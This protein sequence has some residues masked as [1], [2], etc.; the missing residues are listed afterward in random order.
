MFNV[1]IT[2]EVTGVFDGNLTILN[3]VEGEFRCRSIRRIRLAGEGG[4]MVR[5]TG[6]FFIIFASILWSFDGLLRRNLYSLPPTVVVFYEHLIGFL[7]L[8]P[9]VLPELA[10]LKQ[11]KIK[12][13]LP[14]IWVAFFS[15]MLG[16]VLYTAALGQVNY[17]NYSVVVLLQQLEPFVA[18]TFA[19]VFLKEKVTKAYIKWALLAI[20]SAYLLSF[21]DLK[22]NFLGNQGELIAAG[23]AIGAAFAWGSSTVFSRMGLQKVPFY[24]GTAIRFGLT[25]PI[26]FIGVFVLGHQQG[27]TALTTT[28]WLTLI[29]I[30]LSTGMVGLLL[31]YRGLK[32]TQAKV[33]TIAELTWPL[34]AVFIGYFFLHDRLSLTQLLGAAILLFSMYRVTR[35]QKN[36]T[37]EKV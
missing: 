19:A 32:F 36:E 22:I 24:V 28:Q 9:F 16:T 14:F 21:P 12:D 33:S 10:K 4:F 34:S 3:E 25:I 35:L 29:G 18:I 30:T 8:L 11:L 17:I 23:M 27:L 37:I 15:G 6:V 26:T 1:F 5:K 7:I 20:I 13:L 2:P 31:Y